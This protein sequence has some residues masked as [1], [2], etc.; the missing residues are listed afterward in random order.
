MIAET[1]LF[2]PVRALA[3]R[4]S[5][6]DALV[7]SAWQQ[8]LAPS[9]SSAAALLAWGGYGGRQLFPYADIDLLL[10]FSSEKSAAG[11]KNEISSFLQQLWD[12]GL[13]VSQS[14]RTPAEC[15]ELHDNNIELSVSLLDQRYLAGDAAVYGAL[16]GK[17]PRFVHGQ[18]NA[19]VR[20]L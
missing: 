15:A 20:H 4:T 6:V 8:H 5:A 16:L 9:A 14:V 11:R 13:R 10:L 19:L 2:D 18:R 12:S 3:E 1:Q 7:L 17:L